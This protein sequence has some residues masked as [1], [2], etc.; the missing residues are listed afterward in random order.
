MPLLTLCNYQIWF[1]LLIPLLLITS[2]AAK[3]P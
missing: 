1:P 2:Y 3:G